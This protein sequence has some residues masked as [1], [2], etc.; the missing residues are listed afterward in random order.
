M[1][2]LQ[3]TWDELADISRRIPPRPSQP[4]QTVASVLQ[5]TIDRDINMYLD[6][7]RSQR[8]TNLEILNIAHL[9]K[10]WGYVCKHVCPIT[11]KKGLLYFCRDCGKIVPEETLDED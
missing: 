8:L 9:L 7:Q 5:G 1:A 4:S 6:T 11:I 2:E 3:P 10:V